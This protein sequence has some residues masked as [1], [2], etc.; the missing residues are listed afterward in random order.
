ML[1]LLSDISVLIVL[2]VGVKNERIKIK[3]GKN[4]KW[5]LV[6]LYFVIIIFIYR[7]FT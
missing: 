4:M 1:D 7:M 6:L 2:L 3:N 5:G